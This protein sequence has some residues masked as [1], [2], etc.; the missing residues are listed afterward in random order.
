MKAMGRSNMEEGPLEESKTPVLG[1]SLKVSELAEHR[2]WLMRGQRDLEITDGSWPRDFE[3]GWDWRPLAREAR[4]VLDGHKGRLSIH[5]PTKDLPIMARDPKVRAV[6]AERLLSA[7]EFAGEIGATHMVVHSPF[8]AFGA[9]PFMQYSPISSL[10]YE[11]DTVHATMG[12]VLPAARDAGCTLVIENCWDTNPGPLLK[13]VDSFGSEHVRMTLDTGHAYITHRLVGGPP[14]DQWIREA[15]GLLAHLH[16]ADN[17][18]NADRHWSPGDGDLNW[19]ALFEALAELS[20]EPRLI[21][22]LIDPP[23]GAYARA[24]GRLGQR[25]FAR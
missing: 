16:L 6:V 18:G 23:P 20:H 19:F 17:D 9:N 14:P 15:G 13:L 11:V 8:G 2:D 22:E 7:L 4:S 10:E 5:S 24:A 25:G 12:K 1:A 3:D 21:I